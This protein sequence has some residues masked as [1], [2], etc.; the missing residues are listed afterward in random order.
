M[1]RHAGPMSTQTPER[2]TDNAVHTDHPVH[3]VL[4]PG[5]WLGA[6][7]WDDVLPTLCDA[8]LTPHPVTLPGLD[9]V[10]ADRSAIT[11]D[12]H[13]RAVADI[14]D[15]LDG[16]VVLVGHS[17]GGVVVQCV[18]DRRPGRVRRAVYVDSGPLVDGAA[19]HPLPEDAS[20]AERSADIP[21]PPW[22]ELEAQGN[23]LGGLDDEARERFRM[24]A[25]PQPGGVSTAP[26]RLTDERRFA[27]PV[28]VICTSIPSPVLQELVADGRIPAE[29]PRVAS[30][31]YVDLP[32]GHWPMLSRPVELARA[33]A[34]AALR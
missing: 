23:S 1:G 5:S 9:S 29:L 32:T 21:L 12:D 3:A 22:H 11:L 13:V 28:T 18:I 25:V 2:H 33:I 15:G 30:V 34:D 27:V 17:G 26:V 24:R 16:D 10:D 8:G 4:V 6:W 31:E 20:A 19:I 14:V 7:A